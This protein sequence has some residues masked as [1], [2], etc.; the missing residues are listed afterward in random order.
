MSKPFILG[1]TGGIGTGK[2]TVSGLLKSFGARVIDA[3]DISRY[4]LDTGTDCYKD[5]VAAFGNEILNS[6][7]SVDRK[8]LAEI[9][10]HDEEALNRLNGIIHPFVRKTI[11]EETAA[12]DTYEMI[13]WDIPLLFE[14][15]YETETDAVLVVTC[16]LE[17]RLERLFLRSGLSREE[18]LSRMRAQM[19]DEERCRKATYVIDNA[20]TLDELTKKTEV[21]Y[22]QLLS[23][24]HAE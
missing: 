23:E 11:Y 17:V 15:G 16:P 24:K 9:V 7:G 4:A 6:D 2:T 13:V 19:T 20:G 8:K 22:K 10:F 14:S 1:L 21:L 12:A 18:A 3:D 5:T